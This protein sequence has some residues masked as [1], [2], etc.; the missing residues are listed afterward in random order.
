IPVEA[1]SYTRLLFD[2]P[3]ADK[4]IQR[5]PPVAA[6]NAP[7]ERVQFT[8]NWLSAPGTATVLAAI[9]SGLFLRLSAAHWGDAVARTARRLRVPILV[10]CQVRSE[11][12]RVGRGKN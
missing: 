8:F 4:Q 5:T 7:P 2:M 10:I 12:R 3:G 11:E 6:P 9:L 1:T